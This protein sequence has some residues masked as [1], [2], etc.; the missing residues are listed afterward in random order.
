MGSFDSIS[1]DRWPIVEITIHGPP[2]DVQEIDYF[3]AKFIALLQ[4]AKNG[5]AHVP[6]G[7]I[8]II[9]NMDGI[10]NATLQHQ[11]RAASF[12]KDV[13]DLVEPAIF[14][15][16]LVMTNALVRFILECVTKLQ[17]LKSAHRIF[18]SSEAAWEWSEMN[19]ERRINGLG[20]L[21]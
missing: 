2:N 7:K 13:R 21:H 4:L 1:T 12:I 14:S 19:L 6:A 9:M 11:I 17:P 20:P 8:C 16:A 5:N 15:T 18:D 10:L 3:Q